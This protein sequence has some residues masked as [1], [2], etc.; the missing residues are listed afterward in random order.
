MAIL[1][2]YVREFRK[3][4][5]FYTVFVTVICIFIVILLNALLLQDPVLW[6]INFL[7]EDVARVSCS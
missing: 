6:I 7:F 2:Y 3:T 4:F 5:T 1:T